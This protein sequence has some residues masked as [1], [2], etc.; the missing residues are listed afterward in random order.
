MSLWYESPSLSLYDSGEN[1]EQRV[2]CILEHLSM[3]VPLFR[4]ELALAGC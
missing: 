3:D 1:A 2:Q 4:W